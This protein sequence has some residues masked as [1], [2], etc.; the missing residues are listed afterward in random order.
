[1]IRKFEEDGIIRTEE[2]TVYRNPFEG[3]FEKKEQSALL[4]QEQTKAV[5]GM[6]AEYAKGVRMTYLLHGVTGSG[7]TEVY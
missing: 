7:K 1:M 6:W 2:K 5:E 3:H 4:N